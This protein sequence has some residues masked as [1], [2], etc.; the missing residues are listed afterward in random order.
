[1]TPPD[2][3]V[4]EENPLR[5]VPL[6]LVPRLARPGANCYALALLGRLAC[7][8]TGLRDAAREQL[9]PR[10]AAQLADAARAAELERAIVAALVRKHNTS[11]SEPG[12][13]YEPVHTNSVALLTAF[14]QAEGARQLRRIAPQKMTRTPYSDAMRQL[15]PACQR[16][17]GRMLEERGYWGL[18][19]LGMT[20]DGETGDEVRGET[21]PPDYLD[22]TYTMREFARD[23]CEELAAVMANGWW[24]EDDA[25]QF[26]VPGHVGHNW[27]DLPLWFE[28]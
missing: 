18:G 25:R 11:R 21:P 12:D 28:R 2:A 9:A 15:R 5:M 6:L 13:E 8:D 10:R 1:M 19:S 4:E 16:L 7:V 24:D 3:D 26:G 14:V 27:N 20:F 17:E 22:H 23:L